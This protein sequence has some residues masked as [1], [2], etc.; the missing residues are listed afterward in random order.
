MFTKAVVGLDD[1]PATA[2]DYALIN[3][4]YVGALAGIGAVLHRQGEGVG[5][6]DFLQAVFRLLKDRVNQLEAAP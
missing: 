6:N 2:V 5:A 4:S 3:V 1:H